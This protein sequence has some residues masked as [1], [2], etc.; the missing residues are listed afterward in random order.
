MSSEES[1]IDPSWWADAFADADDDGPRR[2]VELASMRIAD[3]AKVAPAGSLQREVLTA[4]HLATSAMLR[5]EDWDEPF[6]PMMVWDGQRSALPDD[7]NGT[8][9]DLLRRTLPLVE[10]RP[11]RARLA[12]VLW[13]ADR[14]D[15]TMLGLAI[16]SYRAASLEPHNWH[17]T[18]H[19]EWQR[20]VELARRR[21][22]AELAR[23][24]EMSDTLLARVLSGDRS[25]GFV[26]CDMSDILKRCASME[27][28]E[29]TASAAKFV[30]LAADAAEDK[31]RLS[32]HLERT[33]Q[34][35]L[36]TVDDQGGL[37]ASVERVAEL[38][39]AEAE[40]RLAAGSGAALAAD[41]FLEKAIA[42]L[43]KLPRSYRLQQGH[44]QRLKDLRQRLED[45]REHALESM[46]RITTDPIDLTEAVAET[47]R[48]VS[49]LAKF[50][51]LAA[52]A[53]IYPL[54]DVARARAQAEELAEGSL[55]H[56]LG[57]VTYSSDGRKVASSD[58]AVDHAEAAIQ[59]DMI[60]G[61]Q[62]TTGIVAT[63]FIIPAHEVVTFEH[64]YDLGFLQRVCVESPLVPPGHEDLW[65][66][67]LRHGLN[68]DFASAAA[69][70]IP[71]MEQL[72]RGVLKRRGVH[73]L[74]VDS[75]GVE[76]EKSLPSLLAMSETA[77][78]LGESLQF[79]LQAMLVDQHGPNLRHKTAH[80][81]LDDNQAWSASSLYVWWLCLRLVVVPL[82]SMTRSADDEASD[83]GDAPAPPADASG[84]PSP[85]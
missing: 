38:Y 24:Q 21:G 78:I 23:L 63:G 34:Q 19:T 84:T 77:Q 81:L 29:R 57:N 13:M 61:L 7:L 22:R 60:R 47:R 26:L 69:V 36:A 39:V 30:E 72:V 18:G 6:K 83:D 71:Q 82:W 3:L 48:R 2:V 65:A 45:S 35:W 31:A 4:L 59:S 52:M 74:F 70:L 27:A 12:D 37:H 44:D 64:R 80:G 58:G 73:T 28:P 53:T 66:R 56:L 9:L 79:E 51:A 8:Q 33:A 10:Q 41:H 14:S 20:A 67:G 46:M 1:S 11:M 68:G 15:H 55:R 42:T 85:Q 32:R 40:E 25:D 76:S 50:D 49:G 16:D 17:R 5:P 54:T 62:M 43:R 75:Y